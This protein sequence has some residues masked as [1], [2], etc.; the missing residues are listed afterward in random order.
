MN[1]YFVFPSKGPHRSFL[2]KHVEISSNLQHWLL[3]V[4]KKLVTLFTTFI[5][6]RAFDS[7]RL[8]KCSTFSC[9]LSTL[10]IDQVA[11]WFEI[12]MKNGRQLCF[13]VLTNSILNCEICLLSRKKCEETI[14]GINNPETTIFVSLKME[15]LY[16]LD[17]FQP[18]TAIIMWK[19]LSYAVGAQDTP[20]KIRKTSLK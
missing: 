13:F 17:S 7:S 9:C 6:S 3:C 19:G 8:L 1:F 16:V 12:N 20:L 14:K 11:K 2:Q 10:I 15:L 18:V 4:F 5:I